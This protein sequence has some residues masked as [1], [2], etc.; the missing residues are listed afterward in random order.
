MTPVL[1]PVAL[2]AATTLLAASSAFASDWPTFRGPGRTAVAPDTDLLESWPAEGP[3]LVWE[4]KGAG[5]GYAS[6]AIVGNRRVG[7]SLATRRSSRLVLNSGT[8][9]S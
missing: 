3:P 2:I 7:R 9:S 4:T 5:R 8:S 1:R 6:V